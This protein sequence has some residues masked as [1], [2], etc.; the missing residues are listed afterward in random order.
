[1]PNISTVQ[2]NKKI[3]FV[4]PTW[5]THF[6]IIQQAA[7][8][9][10]KEHPEYIVECILVQI[11]FAGFVQSQSFYD[12]IDALKS[13]EIPVHVIYK[14]YY[15]D[16]VK[17]E[18]SKEV[19]VQLIQ[20]IENS[21]S[22]VYD[23]A[24][25]EAWIAAKC[26][27]IPTIC[28]IPFQLEPNDREN[29]YF[30]QLLEINKKDIQEID[31]LYGVD[32]ASRF[33]IASNIM[34]IPSE[35]VNVLYGLPSFVQASLFDYNRQLALV[36]YMTDPESFVCIDT[37]FFIPTLQTSQKLIYVAFGSWLN[38]IPQTQECITQIYNWLI[39]S[40]KDNP[41]Y[42]FI[43]STGGKDYS[44]LLTDIPENFY[45][46]TYVP[47]QIEVLQHAHLFITHGGLHSVYESIAHQVPM[48]VIPFHDCQHYIARNV[49]TL[50]LGKAAM[51]TESDYQ[52]AAFLGFQFL[53]RMTLNQQFLEEAIK[54]MLV[55][56]DVYQQRLK[57]LS[58]EKA[59][60][61]ASIIQNTL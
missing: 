29:M 1:Y 50:K 42:I 59:D 44:S 52:K 35:Q 3:I 31:S 49:E 24:I 12:K 7:I 25:F 28:S 37:N 16:Y 41:E 22:V 10:K 18:N 23:F 4:T 34:F 46:Y 19:I 39:K 21:D 14:A 48:F 60:S 33:E 57:I 36:K 2:H 55:H 27:H 53:P 11:E 38:K 6:S 45:F 17:F 40:F 43:I 51:H 26:Q 9:L 30:K 54:E 20:K 8:E 13:A 15:D 56:E 47:S 5:F 32:L 58:Q 61:L